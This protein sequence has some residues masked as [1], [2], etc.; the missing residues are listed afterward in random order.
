ML[1]HVKRHWNETRGDQHDDWGTSWWYFEVAADGRVIRQVEQYESGTLL[2]Y[3]AKR[4][5]D[6]CGGLALEPLDLSESG[7][8]EILDKEFEHVWELASK[9]APL[10]SQQ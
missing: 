10:R 4:D 3:D 8:Q 9:A 1:K 6:T 5:I 2:H 7:Y